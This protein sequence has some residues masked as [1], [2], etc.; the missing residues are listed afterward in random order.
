LILI[1]AYLENTRRASVRLVVP[2]GMGNALMA[3]RSPIFSRE[4]TLLCGAS[5]MRESI[6]THIMQIGIVVRDLEATIKH[7]VDAYGIGPWPR[8]E[9]LT[10]EDAQDVQIDGRPI[11]LWRAAATT[12]MVVPVMWERIAPRDDESIFARFLVGG[13]VYSGE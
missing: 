6:F 13:V 8:H 4:Y 1:S 2:G 11:A 9:E 5:P 10:P 12:A 3:R 7:Y